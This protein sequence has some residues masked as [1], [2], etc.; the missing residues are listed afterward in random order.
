MAQNRETNQVQNPALLAVGARPD[1]L[2]WRQQSGVFRT[3]D[4][5][6]RVVRIGVPGLA[7]SMAVVAVTITPDMVGKTIGVAVAPEFKTATGKQSQA[8][9]LWQR[10]FEARG[11]VYRL[12]RSAAD[13]LGLVDDV[14]RGHW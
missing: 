10:A 5:P 3:Y 7:D 6:S 12:V 13:M 8:Q 11:G 9:Q 4:D 2:I 1:V 14:Q